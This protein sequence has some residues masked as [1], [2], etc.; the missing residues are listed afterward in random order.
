M[1]TWRSRQAPGPVSKRVEHIQQAE[2]GLDSRTS[3]SMR[4]ASWRSRL[5]R[6]SLHP[7]TY[8]VSGLGV[9]CD[10]MATVRF[11]SSRPK[12]VQGPGS[13]PLDTVLVSPLSVI[14]CP[15][16]RSTPKRLPT[17]GSGT[18][19]LRVVTPSSL[20]MGEFLS[21]WILKLSVVFELRMSRIFEPPNSKNSGSRSK[22]LSSKQRDPSAP[23]VTR[24]D[25]APSRKLPSKAEESADLCPRSSRADS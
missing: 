3:R 8:W 15:S 21:S 12:T 20:C 25:V 23:G 14:F 6:A 9:S 18:L 11:V 4:F 22:S 7:F 2:M 1:C 13:E 10:A 17:P 19:D 5:H 24:F 16:S